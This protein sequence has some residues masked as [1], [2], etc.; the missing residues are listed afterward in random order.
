M[1]DRQN[2]KH[3]LL[4]ACGDVRLRAAAAGMMA[5]A[6]WGLLYPELCFTDSTC[7]QVTVAD[8]QELAVGQADYRDILD[9][10]GDEIVVKS[11]L[12]EWLEE[13]AGKK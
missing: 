6:W 9:A 3:I 1:V 13:K 10:T 7:A 5:L 12:L 4:K 11:R 8:G 2:I